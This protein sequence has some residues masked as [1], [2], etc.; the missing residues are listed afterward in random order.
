MAPC[1]AAIRFG[2]TTVMLAMDVSLGV[3]VSDDR[4]HR[5]VTDASG[6]AAS[7]SS[8]AQTISSNAGGTWR[9]QSRANASRTTSTLL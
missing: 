8:T 9:C 4:A 6:R 7:N 1:A 2:L 3:R 5:S